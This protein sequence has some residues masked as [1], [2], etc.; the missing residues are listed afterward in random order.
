MKDLI[1]HAFFIFVL[2]LF[3]IRGMVHMVYL[4][5][6]DRLVVC[7]LFSSFKLEGRNVDRKRLRGQMSTSSK[8]E[9]P[10]TYFSL[11]FFP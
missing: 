1:V 11:V 10:N 7:P 9:G 6:N 3:G 8:L 5:N 4:K 2:G